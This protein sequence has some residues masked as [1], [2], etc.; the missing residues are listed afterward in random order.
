M[1]LRESHGIFNRIMELVDNLEEL[2]TAVHEHQKCVELCNVD[3]VT[4]LSLLP[5][6][7]FACQ[8][9]LLIDCS[10]ENYNVL[11]YLNTIGFPNGITDFTKTGKRYLPITRLPPIEDNTVLGEYEDRIL[12]QASKEEWNNS[13]KQSLKHLTSELV[14]N[15]NEHA[16]IGHYWLFAQYWENKNTCEIVLA[17]CGIGY[18]KSYVGTEFEVNNDFDAIVNA[19][20]GKSSKRYP[21]ERGYGIPT[22]RNM[23]VN[24]YGGKLVIIS[25][26][27][28]IYYRH[29]KRREFKLKSYW[30]GSLVGI[31]FNIKTINPY[32]YL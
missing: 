3:F 27:S 10:E 16:K 29:D 24:G 4:P 2:E 17:D 14:N 1:Q 23:F 13:F 32:D 22:I 9:N 12:S 15:V 28:G 5:L 7:T 18:R 6:V 8:N 26:D 31:N 11:S 19:L 20:E 30:Q 25:G 21:Q